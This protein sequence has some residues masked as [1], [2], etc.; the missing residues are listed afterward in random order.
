MDRRSAGVLTVPCHVRGVVVLAHGTGPPGARDRALARELVLGG[1]ATL[2]V[3]D[4]ADGDGGARSDALVAAIDWLALDAAVGDLPPILGELPVACVGTGPGAG[5][6]LAAAADRP[7][8]VAAVVP[9]DLRRGA[10]APATAAVLPVAGDGDPAAIRG[11][12]VDRLARG[13]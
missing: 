12:L 3:E 8:R 11:W 6:A 4:D 9:R 5:A 7:H 1:L 13:R 2:L 10:G